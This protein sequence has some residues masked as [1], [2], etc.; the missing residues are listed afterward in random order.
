MSTKLLKN[1]VSRLC[2][3]FIFALILH[4]FGYAQD[5]TKQSVPLPPSASQGIKKKIN[6]EPE[7]T[8]KIA[9]DSLSKSKLLPHPAKKA[10]L[11]GK[12]DYSAK[13]SLRFDVK[14]RSVSLYNQADINYQD[15]KLKA[16][17]VKIDFP[18]NMVFAEGKQ[19]STGKNQQVPE[20]T[21]GSQTFKS[22]TI[23]YNYN[24]KQG[25]IQNVVTKQ[26]EG[27]LH[28]NIV[29]KM[30]NDITYLKDEIGRAHV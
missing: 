6:A 23:R 15:I 17:F 2:L 3:L 4:G 21:Q 25:Y 30:E 14:K 26:D 22:K 8:V 9:S 24:T 12:V 16:A 27:Y 10:A 1:P 29:K 19:D 5:T 18:D 11:K 13:D 7:D 28:G 20:F